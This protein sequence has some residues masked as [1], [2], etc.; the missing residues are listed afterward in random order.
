[1]SKDR[2][3]IGT[4]GLALPILPPERDPRVWARLCRIMFYTPGFLALLLLKVGE[5]TGFGISVEL[6]MLGSMSAIVGGLYIGTQSESAGADHS[7]RIGTWCGSLV[8]ELLAVVPILCAVPSLFHELANSKLLHAL[9]PG[10][11]DISLG[12]SELLPAVAIL[13]FM[14][15]Q[16]AGFGTLHYIV[17]RPMNWAINIGILGLIIA[18]TVANRQGAFGVE[19]ALVGV[20]VIAMVIT[21]FYGVLKLRQM[22]TLYDANSPPKAA[23]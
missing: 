17:S 10:A 7:S 14:L 20:L 22:Q 23:K 21:L 1:M 11:V 15:Y 16:L 18:S 4:D 2:P 13:P 6:L 3:T 9:T 19:K 8:L 5:P 12:A